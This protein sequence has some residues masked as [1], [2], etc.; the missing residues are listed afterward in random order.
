MSPDQQHE[1]AREVL[2]RALVLL[3][4]YSTDITVMARRCLGGDGARIGNN[5]IGVIL[6]LHGS[7]DP[8]PSGAV[9]DM[10]GLD[11]SQVSKYL[12]TLANEG[13]VV[14]SRSAADAR[15]R[16]VAL[17]VAGRRR[18]ARFRRELADYF[19]AAAPVMK[20]ALPLLG[21]A[22]GDS[23]SV[24]ALAAA[25]AMSAAG[26][27]YISD[28]VAALQPFGIRGDTR[29]RYVLGLLVAHGPQRPSTFAAELQC[30]PGA[31]TLCLDRL[32]DAGLVQRAHD[33][34]PGNRRSVTVSLTTQGQTAASALLDAFS[35]HTT[36]LGAAL[37]RTVPPN[38]HEGN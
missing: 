21:D 25:V 30:D 19:A 31:I 1:G 8:L 23:G 6:A 35:R 7:R 13:A 29:E 28:A 10:L 22:G 11:P 3:Q 9:A 4:R 24:D 12:T 14:R 18:V 33:T 20:E 5:E 32:Q 38:I 17:T 26:A 2:A 36:A 15:V 16:E 27:G 37:A 34:T